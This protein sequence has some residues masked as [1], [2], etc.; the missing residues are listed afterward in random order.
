[1]SDQ[2]AVPVRVAVIAALGSHQ[3][4]PVPLDDRRREHGRARLARL[5]SHRVQFDNRHPE[6]R[7]QHLAAGEMDDGPVKLAHG[8][9]ADI[10]QVLLQV[11]AATLEH[12]GHPANHRR[13]T[14]SQPTGLDAAQPVTATVNDQPAPGSRQK[15]TFT[16]RAPVHKY[17]DRPLNRWTIPRALTTRSPVDNRTPSRRY[18][19]PGFGCLRCKRGGSWASARTRY[20]QRCPRCS[21]CNSRRCPLPGPLP[22]LPGEFR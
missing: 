21:R 22:G 4:H 20:L 11:H 7:A 16:P 15:R 2:V 3:H 14:P 10:G 5:A 9:Q 6:G 19:Q 1:M 18:L 17:A 12:D 13:P 8:L